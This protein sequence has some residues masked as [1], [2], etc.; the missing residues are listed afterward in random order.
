MIEVLPIPVFKGDSILVKIGQHTVLVDTGPRRAFTKGMLK[1]FLERY[2]PID[3]L[4][5]THND[6]DHIGGALKLLETDI[7]PRMYF[8]SVW[9]NAFSNERKG[10]SVILSKNAD[11]NLS[12]KQANYIVS[13]LI[14]RF[15]DFN[16]SVIAGLKFD[17]GFCSLTTLSPN[18]GDLFEL[19][20]SAVY[21][22]SEELI[23]SGGVD[24]DKTILELASLPFHESGT[25]ANKTSIAVLLETRGRNL[26]LMGDAFPSVVENSIR[27][28]GFNENNKIKIDV[29]KVSHHGSASS[30]S[31]DLLAIIDC[32]KFI[33]STDG[34]NGLPRKECL[35]R[36]VTHRHDE[37]KLYFNYR[38][39]ITESIFLPNEHLTHN[40][41]VIYLQNNSITL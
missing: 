41:Q 15:G 6:E 16:S 1:D 7:D 24:Y 14:N 21:S 29:M 22:E 34:S 20:N 35:A 39:A 26:L 38:N 28:L 27:M 36:V 30:I 31:P 10:E 40:F 8:R 4:I 18:T 9:F 25:L 37:V 12:A 11:L 2:K 19:Q 5:L 17:L 33:I 23:L 13:Q 32:T 3:L